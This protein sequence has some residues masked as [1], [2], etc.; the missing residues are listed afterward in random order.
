MQDTIV[1]F[2]CVCDDLLKALGHQDDRQTCFS[3]AEV[4]TVPLVACA[5]FG[6]N[7]ALARRFLH[8]HGYT[9]NTLSASR[10]ARRLAALPQQI[11]HTLFALLG[12]VF[13]THNSSGVYVVDSLPIAVCDNIRIP[14]AK[15]FQGEAYRGYIASKHRYFYGL[16][17][18]LLVTQTGQPVEFVLAAGADCDI[19]TFKGFALD[20]PPGSVIHADKGYTDYSEEDLLQEAGSLTLLAQRKKNSKRP[21]PAWVE[22]LSHPVRKRIETSFSQ[23]TNLFPKHIHAVTAQGFVLK[24]VCFLL[25][26]SVQCLSR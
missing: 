25:A 21:H 16:R 23:L 9:L 15:L 10:F 22:F 24:L 26:F 2:Y 6:G 17:V 11:W 13:K 7:Q 19:S 14:R 18:H 5:F 20:L 8:A 3:S 1:T 12:E 4:M